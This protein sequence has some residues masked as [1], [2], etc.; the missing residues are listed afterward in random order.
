MRLVIYCLLLLT[1]TAAA[2]THPAVQ[3]ALDWQLPANTCEAPESLFNQTIVDSDGVP[4][5]SRK[6]SQP[7]R[8]RHE[9]RKKE[10]D[11]CVRVYKEELL[12]TFEEMRG[13]AKHGLTQAQANIILGKL[14]YIQTVIQDPLGMPPVDGKQGE[15]P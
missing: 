11:E 6:L 13:V 4:S 15:K 7:Q 10:Y 3:N 8:K 1:F 12:E 5:S 14:K 9:R 2:E